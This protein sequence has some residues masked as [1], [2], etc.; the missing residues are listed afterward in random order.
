MK[1]LLLSDFKTLTGWFHDKCI[2]INPE[3]CSYMCLDKNNND[4]HTSSL[5]AFNLKNSNKETIL[6]IK[7]D[8]KL[9]LNSHIK[10]LYTKA[11]QKLCA[12]LRISNYFEQNEKSLLYRSV[13]K[14]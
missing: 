12:L 11:C 4:D 8:R 14:P 5:N 13:I 7:I 6:G 10:T 1:T 2:I 3:K 9:T